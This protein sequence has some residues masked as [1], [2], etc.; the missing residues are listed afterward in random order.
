VSFF[1]YTKVSID[2]TT[3]FVKTVVLSIDRF[4]YFKCD[5]IFWDGKCQI[6]SQSSY[7]DC[8]VVD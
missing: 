2:N 8:C 6:Y 3:V 4:L 5:L 1:K 7:K